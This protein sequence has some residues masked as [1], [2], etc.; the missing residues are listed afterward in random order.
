M[1]TGGKGRE[2]RDARERARIYQARQQLHEGQIRRRRRDNLLAAI[3][4]GIV[5][6]AAVGGQVA[7]FTAGPGA[8]EPEPTSSMDPTPAPS[9]DATDLLPPAQPVGDRRIPLSHPLNDLGPAG[10]TVTY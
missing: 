2:T 8:P 10:R 1:A 6:L 4:G 5:I 3:G 9:P 7:Y